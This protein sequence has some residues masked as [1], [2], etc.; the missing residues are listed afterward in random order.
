M[1]FRYWLEAVDLQHE[2]DDY[3]TMA[4]DWAIDLLTNAV[5]KFFEYKQQ[6]QQKKFTNC[7]LEL[8]GGNAEVV[9]IGTTSTPD[10]RLNIDIPKQLGHTQLHP[11]ATAKNGIVIQ[12]TPA[13]QEITG[14][15]LNHGYIL[16][17]KLNTMPLVQSSDF[18]DDKVQLMLKRLRI[19]I[20]HEMT[21]THSSQVNF[22]RPM[23]FYLSNKIGQL[24]G[25]A[26]KLAQYTS[27]IVDYYLD[28]GEMRA[29]A[30]QYA[31]MYS[32]RF[33]GESFDINKI[34]KINDRAGKLPR[35]IWGMS[36]PVGIGAKYWKEGNQDLDMQPYEQ[37]L[38]SGYEQ[39]HRLMEYF[40]NQRIRLAKMQQR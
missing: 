10:K 40:I 14:A 7:V 36:D 1:H 25:D 20:N 21:H 22:T 35:F 28:P 31:A 12:L 11:N 19:Q 23:K 3:E 8:A 17:I 26:A 27:G 38:K 39:F 6:G 37:R 32:V 2:S 18:N 5:K 9:N 13:T 34:G 16:E 33:P 29:H 15:Q 24:G 4:S 30:K